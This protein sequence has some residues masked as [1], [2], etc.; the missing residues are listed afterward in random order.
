MEAYPTIARRII[1]CPHDASDYRLR[2]REEVLL[3]DRSRVPRS[4][5]GLRG[6]LGSRIPGF[7]GRTSCEIPFIPGSRGRIPGFGGRTKS[8][9][10]TNRRNENTHHY[11]SRADTIRNIP[12]LKR[13]LRYSV[14][15]KVLGAFLLTTKASW[16]PESVF[17]S[18]TVY[19]M[20]VFSCR[21]GLSNEAGLYT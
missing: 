19:L 9:T 15:V 6:K 18:T 4:I 13:N 10:Y 12:T 3:F 11:S 21:S 14:I 17:P 20:L 16:R 7:E 8:A 1:S 2:D 5:T